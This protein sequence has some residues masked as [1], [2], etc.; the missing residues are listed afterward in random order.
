MIKVISESEFESVYECGGKI[1]VVKRDTKLSD[2]AIN[3][4][5]E[6]IIDIINNEENLNEL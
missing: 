4:F 1:F 6:S 2:D 3:L 5:V